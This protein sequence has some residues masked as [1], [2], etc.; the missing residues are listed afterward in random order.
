MSLNPARCP[1]QH[2]QKSKREILLFWGVPSLLHLKKKTKT[3]NFL[4]INVYF[5]RAI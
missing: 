1:N 3:K 4:K 5:S 2:T